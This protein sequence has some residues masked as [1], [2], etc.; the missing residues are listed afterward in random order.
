MPKVMLPFVEDCNGS[1]LVVL[2]LLPA[3]RLR[4]SMLWFMHPQLSCS[5][6]VVHDGG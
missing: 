5:A 4:G 2:E 6:G 3:M 1:V